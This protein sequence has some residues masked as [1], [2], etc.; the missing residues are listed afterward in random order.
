MGGTYIRVSGITEIFKEFGWNI[1]E[2]IILHNDGIKLL[3]ANT[4]NVCSKHALLCIL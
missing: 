3:K 1:L 4:N 2:Q